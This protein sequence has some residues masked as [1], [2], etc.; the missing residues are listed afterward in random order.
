[1]ATVE[2]TDPAEIARQYAVT[3]WVYIW[4][5]LRFKRTPRVHDALP[6]QGGWLDDGRPEMSAEAY[7]ELR[8]DWLLAG[9]PRDLSSLTSLLPHPE[10]NGKETALRE[11]S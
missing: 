11:A 4:S 9:A 3:E 1:L 7:E 10:E 5:W 6:Q 2:I 8:L